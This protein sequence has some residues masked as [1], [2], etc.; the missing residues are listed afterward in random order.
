[1]GD[2]TDYDPVTQKFS[3]WAWKLEGERL[4]RLEAIPKGLEKPQTLPASL[5]RVAG[6]EVSGFVE[7]QEAWWILEHIPMKEFEGIHTRKEPYLQVRRLDKRTGVG[8]V[9]L[10][11]SKLAP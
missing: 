1:V 4:V 3:R 9:L 6:W 8:V 5:P 7:D 10:R 11:V 2:Q